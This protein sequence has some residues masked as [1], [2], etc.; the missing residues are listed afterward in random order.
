M[1]EF[2]ERLRQTRES[3]GL[4]LSQAAIET[5]ILQ[6][7]LIALEEGAFDRLPSDVVAKGFIRN[8][9]RYLD[10]PVN[11]MLETYRRDRGMSGTIRI[12]PTSTMT[13]KHSYVLPSFFGVFVITIVLVGLTYGILSVIGRVGTPQIARQPQAMMTEPFI[14]DSTTLTEANLEPT[15]VKEN[16]RVSAMLPN[17]S[18]SSSDEKTSS[19]ILPEATLQ[20]IA[21]MALEDS[22][23]SEPIVVEVSV[24]PGTGGSWLRVRT[25]GNIAYEQIMNAGERAVFQAQHRVHI[26]AGNPTV[27]QVSVNGLRPEPIGAVAGHPVNWYWPPN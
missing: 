27:V 7:W 14:P 21:G 4:T 1:N 19:G 11:E 12:L 2:G 9:T 18:S 26:R 10:L 17:A 23:S 16:A 25:D 3:K 13:S 20:P 22:S 8:Y 6:K 24:Q 15:L 5:R